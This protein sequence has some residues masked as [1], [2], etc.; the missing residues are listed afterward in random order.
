MG[1]WEGFYIEPN[2]FS[3]FLSIQFANRVNLAMVALSDCQEAMVRPV[4]LLDTK[5]LVKAVFLFVFIIL[6]AA[7]D[8]GYN[9][10][11]S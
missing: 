11:L 2:Y 9:R 1:G 3:F 7:K 5:K 10:L 4:G 6:F 8:K